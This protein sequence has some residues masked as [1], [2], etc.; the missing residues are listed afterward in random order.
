LFR[1]SGLMRYMMA[2][3]V[4]HVSCG[5]RPARS[6]SEAESID[7]PIRICGQIG[8]GYPLDD[9]YLGCDG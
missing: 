9:Q 5:R 6:P 2:L 8:I 3:D 1:M 4:E 7:L